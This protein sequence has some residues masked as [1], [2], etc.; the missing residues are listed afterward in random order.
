M[1]G[2]IARLEVADKLWKPL[3]DSG[4]HQDAIVA[5]LLVF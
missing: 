3:T 4:R 2:T 5:Q 1:D